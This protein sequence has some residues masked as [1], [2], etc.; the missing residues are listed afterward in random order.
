L[1]STPAVTATGAGAATGGFIANFMITAPPSAPAAT[2]TTMC[3][4]FIL[5]IPH[6]SQ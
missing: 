4:G 2:N 1:A 5:S 3:S 6:N